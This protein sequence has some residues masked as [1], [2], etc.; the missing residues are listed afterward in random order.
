MSLSDSLRELGYNLDNTQHITIKTIE[1][2]ND[3]VNLGVDLPELK[4]VA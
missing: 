1:I 4:K 2:Y 3:L